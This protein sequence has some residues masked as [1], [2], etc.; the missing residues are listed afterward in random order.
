MENILVAKNLSL[1][2]DEKIILNDINFNI[3]KNSINAILGSNNCGK[4]T[5]IKILSGITLSDGE[6]YI[7]DL[8]L[9]PMNSKIILLN[10]GVVFT[11]INKQ[12]LFEDVISEL[13]FPLENLKYSRKNILNAIDMMSELLEIRDI[14]NVKNRKLS[15]YQKVLVLIGASII[16]N[17][18]ILFLDDVFRNLTDEESVSLFKVL[19]KIVLKRDLTVIYTTSNLLDVLEADRALVMDGGKILFDDKPTAILEL[20]NELAKIGIAIPTMID[21]SMKLKFY[22]LVDKIYLDPDKVVDQLWP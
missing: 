14:V 8:L 15:T 19:K 6:I 4:T 3:E 18:R 2:C 21:L 22:N 11:D 20:D 9:K 7:N 17:P 1:I 13:S 10:I 16:H 12:F 5:L